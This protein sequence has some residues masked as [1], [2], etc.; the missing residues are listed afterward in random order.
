[1]NHKDKILSLRAEGKTYNEIQK[2][3]GCSKG[4]I[5][6]HLGFGQKQKTKQRSEKRRN[7]LRKKIAEIKEAIGC[8]DCK[9]KYPYY[10]LQFDHIKDDKIDNIAAMISWY[11]WEEI[12]K[13]IEKCEVVCANCHAMRTYKRK[14]PL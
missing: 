8:V 2:I 6:Y 10:V 14:M 3:L 7:E 9:T 12:K 1:M 11:P 4:T 13:E 5:S